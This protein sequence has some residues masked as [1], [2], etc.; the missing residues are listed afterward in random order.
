MI[1][2]DFGSVQSLL[3]LARP[4]KFSTVFGALSLN[5][6]ILIVPKLVLI[7]ATGF[8]T[9]LGVAALSAANALKER[10][11]SSARV[12]SVFI[13]ENRKSLKIHV[14]VGRGGAFCVN[15]LKRTDLKAELIIG[16]RKTFDQIIDV[17][18]EN[19]Q[20]LLLA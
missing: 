10:V 12:D 2:L 8:F 11:N 19:S 17:K 6:V 1:L 15:G 20:L 13:Y 9:A 18:L 4:M 7:T 14:Q 3:P 16:N 5:K